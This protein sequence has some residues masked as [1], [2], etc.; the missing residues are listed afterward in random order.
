MTV[1]DD[2]AF[3]F[4]IVWTGAVFTHLRYFVASQIAH[5][6]ARF[7]F[8]G[9]GCEPGQLE[10]MEEFATRYPDRVVEVLETSADMGAH[11]VALDAVLECRDDGDY[12]CMI[13]PDILARGPFVQSF[14]ERL[15]DCIGVTSGRGVWRDDDLVPEGQM[16]VSGEF[17]YSQDGYLFGS[18]HFAMYNRAPLAE[19]MERWGVGFKS[20]GPDLSDA[21]RAKV[22]AAGHKYWLYD[23]GKLVNVLLQEDGNTLCHFENPNLMHIGG[24]SHYLY[25]PEELLRRQGKTFNEAWT[26]WDPSRFEVAQF[27]GTVLSELC[28][29][30]PAPEIPDGLEPSMADRLSM[31]R[32]ELVELIATYAS[33]VDAP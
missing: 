1:P 24:L 17:F 23:T 28:A 15:D 9:N 25:P 14:A 27:T 32:N 30:R 31:V 12:F 29:H 16:G 2:D 21:A 20:A 11:G 18:P 4:N 26:K 8:V 19:T 7:R 13:D 10:M 6:G 3:V 22:E 33:A 5:S